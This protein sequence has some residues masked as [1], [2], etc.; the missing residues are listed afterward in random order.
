MGPNTLSVPE[1]FDEL[2]VEAQLDYLHMLWDRIGHATSIPDWHRSILKTRR[3]AYQQD[4]HPGRPWSEVREE[5]SA[6]LK[7]TRDE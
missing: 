3:E 4:K 2:S 5:I 1:G 7:S 6:K